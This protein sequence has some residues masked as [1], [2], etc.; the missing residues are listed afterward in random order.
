MD[1][2]HLN[3]RELC[4]I[5]QALDLMGNR[6]QTIG[7]FEPEDWRDLEGAMD[8]VEERLQRYER[9]PGGKPMDGYCPK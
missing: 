3:K 5:K 1:K 8:W 4:T 2:K 9:Y 6:A 7:D